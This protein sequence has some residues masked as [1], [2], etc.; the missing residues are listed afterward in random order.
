[1]REATANAKYFI[2]IFFLY[3][4]YKI[5]KI[6]SEHNFYGLNLTAYRVKTA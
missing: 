1:M 2:Y 4:F 5:Y 6:F 3:I